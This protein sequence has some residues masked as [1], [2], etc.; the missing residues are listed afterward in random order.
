MNNTPHTAPYGREKDLLL[1]KGFKFQCLFTILI[2]P[3]R[4]I[5]ILAICGTHIRPLVQL[6]KSPF[7][8]PQQITNIHLFF[9]Y[10]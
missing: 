6:P 2:L 4:I 8:K 10:D 1:V 3:L 9:L 7:F 5:F